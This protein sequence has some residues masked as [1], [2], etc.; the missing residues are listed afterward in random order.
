MQQVTHERKFHT[1][2]ISVLVCSVLAILAFV[3]PGLALDTNYGGT[4]KTDFERKYE[5]LTLQGLLLGLE[6]EQYSLSYR[7]GALSDQKFKRTRYFL[8]QETAAAGAMTASIIGIDQTTK[9]L[10]R[11][12]RVSIK[13]LKNLQTVGEVTSIIGASSSGVELAANG[14]HALKDKIKHR[15]S[16][17][18]A[19]FLTDKLKQIDKILAEREALIAS[20]TDLAANPPR[21]A[22]YKAETKLLNIMLDR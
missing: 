1:L 5:R 21:L 16:K 20:N 9:A 14:W 17:T 12:S 13:A 8:G 6:F 19:K 15:D 22:Q 7:I 3:Q 4:S 10:H 11:P 2:A 18:A